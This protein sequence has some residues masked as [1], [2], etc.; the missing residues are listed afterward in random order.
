MLPLK[1]N[2][3][4]FRKSYPEWVERTAELIASSAEGTTFGIFGPWGSGKTSASLALKNSILRAARAPLQPAATLAFSYVDCSSLAFASDIEISSAVE[5]ELR[6]SRVTKPSPAL[7]KTLFTFFKG[8]GDLGKIAAHDPLNKAGMAAVST[9]AGAGLQIE[10][11]QRKPPPDVA[12]NIEKAFVF[13]DD[14]D[15]CDADA[16]WSILRHARRAL[17]ETKTVY[18]IVCDPVVLGHHI[19]NALGVSLAHGFQAVLKYIDVPIKI[20]TALTDEHS[21]SVESRIVEELSEDWALAEVARDAIG[22]IPMRDVLAALPQ[23]SL[24]LSRWD[25]NLRPNGY[26]AENKLK[27]IAEVVFV[28]ALLNTCIPNAAQALGSGKREWLDFSSALNSIC[29]GL[30]GPRKESTESALHRQFGP[31]AEQV[32]GGRMDLVRY[33]RGREIGKALTSL[34]V[35]PNSEEVWNVLWNLMRS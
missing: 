11:G 6:R 1:P 12:K 22:S 18:V 30:T 13:L 27:P 17:P 7:A 24:W 2:P 33:L 21:E 4:S 10:A 19:S 35:G 31:I 28:F 26:G 3:D 34:K 5:S 9:L 8:V 23:A 32:I 25:T 15:R 16:A 20:P 14:L 29:S